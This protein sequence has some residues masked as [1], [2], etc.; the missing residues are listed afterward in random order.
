[1]YVNAFILWRSERLHLCRI[2]EIANL[3]CQWNG[4]GYVLKCSKIYEMSPNASIPCRWEQIR[5]QGLK[6]YGL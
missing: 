6:Y 4:G 3:L 2:M 1:M 5:D